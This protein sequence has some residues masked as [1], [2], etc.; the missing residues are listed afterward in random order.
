M[1]RFVLS[2][3]SITLTSSLNGCYGGTEYRPVPVGIPAGE[4]NLPS[5]AYRPAQPATPPPPAQ[6]G[7]PSKMLENPD[8]EV[9][10]TSEEVW[11]T[12]EAEA[13]RKCE[14]IATTRT[15][16]GGTLV[17]VQGRP[18]QVTRTPSKNGTFKFVC[19][20]RSET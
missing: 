15:Q 11:A 4:A 12:D 17:T 18:Q 8:A 9:V 2:L 10:E 1:R 16:E 5:R 13:T 20:L 14:Q 6:S 7:Q 19:R 3:T